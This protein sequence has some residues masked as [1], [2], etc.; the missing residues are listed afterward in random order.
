MNYGGPPPPRYSSAKKSTWKRPK[1]KI[2]DCNERDAMR[3][4]ETSYNEYKRNKEDAA[5]RKRVESNRDILSEHPLSWRAHSMTRE[6]PRPSR[7][8][9]DMPKRDP[10]KKESS[11]SGL[12]SSNSSGHTRLNSQSAT[13]VEDTF[14]ARLDKLKKLREELGLP[15]QNGT[16][17]TSSSL[18][19]SSAKE[20]SESGFKSSFSSESKYGSTKKSALAVEDD[21]EVP[22]YRSRSR[23]KATPSKDE[24]SSRESR[25]TKYSSY[26]EKREEDPEPDVA[27]PDEYTYKAKSRSGGWRSKLADDLSKCELYD[28]IDKEKSTTFSLPKNDY[29]SK[30]SA[31]SEL[32]GDSGFSSSSGSKSFS[33]TSASSSSYKSKAMDMSDDF[34]MDDSVIANL[35]K[36]LPSSAEILERISKMNLDD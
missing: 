9:D 25:W 14:Q 16:A 22:S 26:K 2:Y 18:S 34:D 32:N 24:E 8:E 17:E 15:Q 21:D 3:F 13:E 27:S 20:S 35:S 1:P 12:E 31:K 7:E 28:N 10:F 4:Y 5:E 29:S 36:K 11:Y 30:F 6:R 23:A 19:K 33:S